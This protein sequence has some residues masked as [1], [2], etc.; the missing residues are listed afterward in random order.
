MGTKVFSPFY[1]R[2]GRAGELTLEGEG[3]TQELIE[4]AKKHLGRVDIC[5]KV[6]I[7]I[8]QRMHWKEE[9]TVRYGRRL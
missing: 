5:N 3:I 2:K 8:S 7:C 9:H 1:R 4:Q 6:S